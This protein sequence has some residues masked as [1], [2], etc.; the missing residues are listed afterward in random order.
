MSRKKRSA[1]RFLILLSAGVAVTLLILYKM[2]TMPAG[3]PADQEAVWQEL[4]TLAQQ[5]KPLEGKVLSM[6]F[7]P[8]RT[9]AYHFGVQTPVVEVEIGYTDETGAAQTLWEIWP[10][11]A[12]YR[13]QKGDPVRVYL[14]PANP[15]LPAAS[16]EL[17]RAK[18]L[19][20]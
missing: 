4:F 15:E 20:K 10:Q 17:L 2:A 14:E 9:Y 16:A 3:T 13:V 5:G 6:N 18:G 1:T 8:A 7:T 12:S 11:A 19:L